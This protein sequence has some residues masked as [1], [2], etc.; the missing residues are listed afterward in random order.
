MKL[1]SL[2]L[3]LIMTVAVASVARAQDVMLLVALFPEKYVAT[4]PENWSVTYRKAIG[5]TELLGDEMMLSLYTEEGV[6]A[7]MMPIDE[8]VT[9]AEILLELDDDFLNAEIPTQDI[10][11]YQFNDNR[12]VIYRADAQFVTVMQLQDGT[13]V[14]GVADVLTGDPFTDEQFSTVLSIFNSVEIGEAFIPERDP[15]LVAL[16]E[17]CWITAPE[18]VDVRL[19][20]GPGFNR[21]AITF[22][23]P[24]GEFKVLGRSE[25]TDGSVW[26]QLDKQAV[27]PFKDTAETWVDAEDV[28][29]RGDCDLVAE[30][31]APPLNLLGSFDQA[32]NDR[33]DTLNSLVGG[34]VPAEGEIVPVDRATYTLFHGDAGASSCLTGGSESFDYAQRWGNLQPITSSLFVRDDG[35]AF[36]FAGIGF[37]RQADGYYVGTLYFPDSPTEFIRVRPQ[38]P[39]RLM[40]FRTQLVGSGDQQCSMSVPVTLA[41]S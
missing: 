34:V 18:G 1:K 24:V 5:K 9:S 33:R 29:K 7:R 11:P 10:L 3:A 38:Q 6:L 40:G 14:Y 17:P 8:T 28:E 27:A 4:I 32:A 16:G 21:A 20:V 13:Y 35:S 37:L 30:S 25:A 22:L 19:R 12:A 2:W 23:P 15:S 31:E 36:L 41:L 39:G 26:Y